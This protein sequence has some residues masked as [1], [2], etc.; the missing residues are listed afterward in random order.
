MKNV[1]IKLSPPEQMDVDT[2]L[3]MAN[4]DSSYSTS[5]I[6]VTG[7]KSRGSRYFQLI[8]IGDNKFAWYNLADNQISGTLTRGSLR[9]VIVS[10]L[11][12]GYD[13]LW[14]AEQDEFQK[15]LIDLWS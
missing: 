14:F 5:G 7:K 13:V 10:E 12:G 2:L 3:T 15:W 8:K 9:D 1:V 11:Q 4:G 6:I